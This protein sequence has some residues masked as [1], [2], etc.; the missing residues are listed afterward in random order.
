MVSLASLDDTPSR[1]I[2]G[3]L[4]EHGFTEDDA[5][6]GMLLVS[7]VARGF[8]EHFNGKV[9]LYLRHYGEMMLSDIDKMF[10]APSS[11]RSVLASAFTYWLQNA[12]CMPLSLVDHS[13]WRFCEENGVTPEQLIAAAD[14]LNIN[15]AFLDDLI[16]ES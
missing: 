9:Q 2:S 15:V 16:N 5:A 8:R 13:M 11:D 1:Q 12:L 4:R 7:T 3:L 10:D 14:D 6:R